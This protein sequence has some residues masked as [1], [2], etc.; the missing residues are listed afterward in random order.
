MNELKPYPMMNYKLNDAEMQLKDGIFSMQEKIYAECMDMRE[1]VILNA[2]A[3]A[4]RH[5]GITELF[6]LD[7]QFVLDALTDALEKW[8]TTE[9]SDG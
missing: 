7:K 3:D 8:R 9:V 1:T 2:V 5:A 4:A 6:L